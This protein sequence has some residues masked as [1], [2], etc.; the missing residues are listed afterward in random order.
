MQ[1]KVSQTPF[2]TIKHQ[3]ISTNADCGFRIAE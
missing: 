3:N 2:L 1:E